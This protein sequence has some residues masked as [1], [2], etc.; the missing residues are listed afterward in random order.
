M[1]RLWLQ[2]LCVLG[3]HLG[4]VLSLEVEYLTTSNFDKVR[5]RFRASAP[6]RTMRSY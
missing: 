5:A 3:L 6:L 2:L 1:A 4:P